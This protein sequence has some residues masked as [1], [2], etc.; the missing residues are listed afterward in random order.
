MGV[1]TGFWMVLVFGKSPYRRSQSRQDGCGQVRC[2]PF[3]G[4]NID[5]T[6]GTYHELLGIVFFIL[7]I[8]KK[9]DSILTG[10][11]LASWLAG[12]TTN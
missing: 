7:F 3:A 9:T 11:L 5:G 1:S 2:S 8:P 6:Y 4:K 10:N 12:R